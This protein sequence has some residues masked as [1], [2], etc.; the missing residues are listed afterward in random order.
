MEFEILKEIGATPSGFKIVVGDWYNVTICNLS[1]YK[2]RITL[3]HMI[4]F[5]SILW[6]RSGCEHIAWLWA[7]FTSFNVDP[8]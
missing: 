1:G 5:V 2:W 3:I 4:G 7:I 6:D 8:T